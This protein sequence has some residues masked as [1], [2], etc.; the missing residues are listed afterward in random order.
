MS[1][2]SARILKYFFCMDFCL[3]KRKKKKK[4]YRPFRKKEEEECQP[5]SKKIYPFSDTSLSL[6]INNKK[7]QHSVF[8]IFSM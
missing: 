1:F 4:E 7:K 6:R 5:G 8:H 2:E 3:Q